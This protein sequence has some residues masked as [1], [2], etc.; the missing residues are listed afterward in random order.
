MSVNLFLNDKVR[1]STKF[2]TQSN[3][4]NS[5]DE[6]TFNDTH[7]CGGRGRL[8][9]IWMED[10]VIPEELKD[11]VEEISCHEIIPVMSHRESGIYRHESAECELMP[12]H[13]GSSKHENP[14][15]KLKITA[16]N[17][18]DIKVIL[19]KVKTGSILPEESYKERQ[20]GKTRQ[21]L[22]SEFMQTQQLL[23]EA[24]RAA[25]EL[26]MLFHRLAR[27]IEKGTL[28]IVFC[29]RVAKQIDAILDDSI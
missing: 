26:R 5:R 16:K 14:V 17:L 24:W 6:M 20:V 1:E 3:K 23:S 4:D 27:S 18:E 11:F 25:A 28:P 8:Y 15:Y 13:T 19:H 2:K 21:Q 7:V 9:V 22:E 10:A 12:G 29:S